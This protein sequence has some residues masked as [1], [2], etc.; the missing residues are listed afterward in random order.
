MYSTTVND[1]TTRKVLEVSHH[2]GYRHKQARIQRLTVLFIT[3][4]I[5]H[6]SLHHGML[7]NF[8]LILHL[9]SPVIN[10]NRFLVPVK[11][12]LINFNELL[13]EQ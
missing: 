7:V 13:N 8:F 12:E 2:E 9:L 5:L 11:I 10:H 3:A 4:N 6:L 1:R